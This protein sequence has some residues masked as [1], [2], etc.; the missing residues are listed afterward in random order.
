MERNKVI[1]PIVVAL[2]FAPRGKDFYHPDSKFFLE[3][4]PGPLSF[5]NRYIDPSQ[6][7]TLK[8][9][10]GSLRIITAT[11]CVMDRLAWYVHGKDPQARVQAVLVARHQP[12]DW[13]DI[14]DWAAAE[15]IDKGVIAGIRAEATPLAT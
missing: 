1:A 11:Q 12:V 8:T 7:T 10:F 5:G 15:G 6:A 4:P 14:S 13:R 9:R 2:G 3:F